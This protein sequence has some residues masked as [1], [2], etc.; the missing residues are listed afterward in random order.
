MLVLLSGGL[1]M[2]YLAERATVEVH[3]VWSRQNNAK[4]S[5]IVDIA[6]ALFF[7]EILRKLRSFQIAKDKT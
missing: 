1:R 4:L 2:P 5:Y 3:A 6:V 7:G